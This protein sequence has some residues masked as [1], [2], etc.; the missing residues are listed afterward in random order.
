MNIKQKIRESKYIKTLKN[1]LNKGLKIFEKQIKENKSKEKLENRTKED[2]KRKRIIIII[3]LLLLLL[4]IKIIFIGNGVKIS[5]GNNRNS[6]I[7]NENTIFE[8]TNEGT[9]IKISMQNILE[10]EIIQNSNVEE[11]KDK[12]KENKR[13][14]NN[15]NNKK[16]VL[17]ENK[18]EPIIEDEKNIKVE[19]NTVNNNKD[20]KIEEDKTNKIENNKN[21]NQ[22]NIVDKEKEENKEND[23]TNN[24]QNNEEDNK[25]EKDETNNSSEGNNENNKPNEEES[26]EP[27]QQEEIKRKY[28]I[29]GKVITENANNEHIATITLYRAGNT[30]GLGTQIAQVKTNKDGTFKIPIYEAKESE[31]IDLNNN[32]IPDEIEE[33]YNIKITKLSY[34]KHIITDIKFNN[35]TDNIQIGTIELIAGDI[36]ET[37]DIEILDL[38]RV[39]HVC[40]QDITKINEKEILK[41]DLNEDGKVDELDSNILTKNYGKIAKKEAWQG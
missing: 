17:N 34:L 24:I 27:I 28:Y 7:I 35:N 3:L 29:E 21:N 9:Q 13:T 33:T 26:K 20:N 19:E 41:C 10:D 23:K 16:K 2:E 4:L 36:D 31:I 39:M 12:N 22:E 11:N 37:D 5:K 1:K 14:D 15:K 8:K 18:K 40:G 6:N 32:D 30:E 38:S 25:E